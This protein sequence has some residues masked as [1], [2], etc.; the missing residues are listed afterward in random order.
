M[1]YIL[2]RISLGVIFSQNNNFSRVQSLHHTHT[3][4]ITKDWLPGE[5]LLQ[6]WNGNFGYTAGVAEMLLQ[7]H[8]NAIHLLPALPDA[9]RKGRIEGLVA[10]GGFVTD[11]EW[12]MRIK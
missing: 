4:Y 7:S 12:G 9:W 11:M 6:I 10:R 3:L 2:L 5:V 8:D 1:K